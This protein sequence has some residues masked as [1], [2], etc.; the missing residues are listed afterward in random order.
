MGSHNKSISHPCG[1]A[2]R[3]T[4]T[5]DLQSLPNLNG[6]L[7]DMKKRKTRGKERSQPQPVSICFIIH[8]KRWSKLSR[9]EILQVDSGKL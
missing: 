2:K 6:I 8:R 9:L 4:F 3:A 5:E 7:E 1:M